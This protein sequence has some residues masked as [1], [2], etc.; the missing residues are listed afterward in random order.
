MAMSKLKA[1]E[2]INSHAIINPVLRYLMVAMCVIG[3]LCTAMY[4]WQLKVMGP[5]FGA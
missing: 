1:S 4:I 3:S 5:V 2:L